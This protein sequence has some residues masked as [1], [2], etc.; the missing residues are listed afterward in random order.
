MK[1]PLLLAVMLAAPSPGAVPTGAASQAESRPS[2]CVALTLPRVEGVDGSATSFAVAVRDLFASFLT[3]PGIKTIQLDARLASQAALEA[4]D[5]GCEHVVLA[6]VTRK[7]STGS[8]VGGVLGRAAGMSAARVPVGGG[9]VGAIAS[10]A[11]SAVGQAIYGLASQTRARDEIELTY[12]LGS[13]DTVAAAKPVSSKAKAK[14]DGE[15]LLTGLVEKAATGILA[16][17]TAGGHR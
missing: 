15:D 16:A 6:T 4:R 2:S 17:A 7:R 5:K 3:G 8:G 11:T 13:P 14:A 9:V 1:L 10:G 12:R